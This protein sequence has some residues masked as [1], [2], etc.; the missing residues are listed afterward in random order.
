MKAQT[1][2]FVGKPACGKST[3]VEVLAK[4]AGWLAFSSGDL[5]REIMR[6]DSPVARKV[7]E[8][9]D[10]GLLQPYWFAMYLYLKALFSIPADKGAVFDGF[11]RKVPE[12]ELIV[13]SLR[14]LGRSFAIVN[15]AISDE[16][17]HRRVEG[18]KQTSGRTDEN[19]V[20]ER[21]K[22]YHEHTEAAIE[23][24][25]DAGVLIEINGEQP[26][27]K[28]AEDVNAALHLA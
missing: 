10:A 16:E 13:E 2:F 26:P 11:N 28:V 17:V 23:I 19:V 18:R 15:V 12:A 20:D 9:N 27:E 3:Q 22:E 4:K 8:D 7:K 5:F 21:L 6:E 14:W 24:F 25:R 1:V